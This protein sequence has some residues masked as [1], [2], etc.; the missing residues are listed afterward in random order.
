MYCEASEEEAG[1]YA[2]I[3]MQG[4]VLTKVLAQQCYCLFCYAL[5]PMSSSKV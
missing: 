1:V 4:T 5:L 3:D 2:R